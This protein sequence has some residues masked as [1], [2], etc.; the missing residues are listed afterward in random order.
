MNIKNI[1]LLLVI[2]MNVSCGTTYAATT[3]RSPANGSTTYTTTPT[4]AWDTVSGATGYRLVL[5]EN[6]AFSG[7]DDGGLAENTSCTDSSC[8]MVRVSESSYE[9]GTDIQLDL[10]KT[11]YW[12]VRDTVSSDWSSAFHFTLA[13]KLEKPVLSNP[14][15]AAQDI[16][17]S[18]Q[19]FRWSS[20][21]GATVYRIVVLEDGHYDDFVDDGGE[22]YCADS[23]TCFTDTTASTNYSGF[24]LKE[25]TKYFWL[26]RAGSAYGIPDSGF[27]ADYFTT[28]TS[29]PV[30][31]K[32]PVLVSGSATPGS[33]TSGEQV[34]FEST[35]ND[36]ENKSVVDVQVR[37]RRQGTTSWQTKTLG[38][39][40]GY[41]FSG[42][43][44]IS[45]T[46][47]TYEY[48]FRASDAD[49]PSGDRTNTTNWLAGGSFDV[50]EE[51]TGEVDRASLDSE[52]YED[53]TVLTGNKTFT[54][55]WTLKNTGTTTWDS[56]Y[57]LSYISG[58]LSTDKQAVAI[59]GTVA[60][61]E[62]FT[63]SVPMKTPE[64]QETDQTYSDYWKFVNPEGDTV[65]VSGSSKI[66]VRI[67][68]AGTGGSQDGSDL[69]RIASHLFDI[70]LNQIDSASGANYKY[71]LWGS[72][73]AE[74]YTETE[75]NGYKGGHSG[76]DMQTK[77]VA[78]DKTADRKFYA[79]SAGTV[80]AAGSD[81]YN[82]I[83]I[84]DEE[85][86]ITTLYLHAREV[87]IALESTV[88]VGTLLGVQGDTA[89]PAEHVH[90]EV[91]KGY[92]TGPA[93]GAVD[94]PNPVPYLIAYLDNNKQELTFDI[95]DPACSGP[96]QCNGDYLEEKGSDEVFVSSD[97]NKLAQAAVH[98]TGFAADGVTRLLLRVQTDSK[99]KFQLLSADDEL[100]SGDADNCRFGTLLNLAETT[101]SCGS[102]EVE[103]VST[104]AGN[105]AFAILKAPMYYPFDPV[106]GSIANVNSTIKAKVTSD[107]QTEKEVT[108]AVLPAPTVLVHGVW[109][110][111]DSMAALEQYLE[112]RGITI[113]EDCRPTHMG[114]DALEFDPERGVHGTV[115]RVRQSIENAINEFRNQNIACAQ[116]TVV[117]HSLGGLLARA[118]IDWEIRPFQTVGNYNKGDIYKIITIGTPHEGS[119]LAN[120]FIEHQCDK[121]GTL[122]VVFSGK[123][124]RGDR[125]RD[126]LD[127][128]DR[129]IG[130]AIYGLQQN[131][132]ALSHIGN[133]D[134]LS[135]AIVGIAP[136][137]SG[138]E[139]TLNDLPKNSGNKGTTI[140]GLL[141]GNNNH[142]TI[143][144][145]QSQMGGIEQVTEI[146]DIVHAAIEDDTDET[147]SNEV[148]EQVFELLLSRDE[149][150]FG[151]FPAPNVD[152]N[153][154]APNEVIATCDANN[155][156]TALR[157]ETVFADLA[158][159]EPQ[160]TLSPSAGTVVTAGS[161]VTI[162][163][164]IENDTP[165]EG[166]DGVMFIVGQSVKTISGTSPYEFSFQVPSKL[167]RLNIFAMA[168]GDDPGYYAASSYLTVVPGETLEQIIPRPSRA[169]LDMLNV[170]F[171]LRIEGKFAS[172]MVYDIT[173]S[174]TGTSY[175]VQAGS[176]EI[177]SVTQEG[178]VTPLRPGEGFINVSNDG[179]SAVVQITVQ[180][181][182]IYDT[183]QDGIN[184]FDEYAAGLDP[185]NPDSDNDGMP[186]GW[187]VANGLNPLL[188]DSGGDA[189][190]DGFSNLDEYLAG[191]DPQDA[192]STP[193]K[194]AVIVP[195][196]F[197]SIQDAVNYVA[198]YAFGG[199]VCVQPGTYTEAKLK[200][201]DGVYLVALS[202]DPAATVIDGNGKDDVITFQ[203]VRVGG[204]IGFTLR[205]SKKNGNAAAVNIAGDK[206]MPLI[207]RNIITDNRHGIRLQGNVMPLLIN[208]TIADNTGDGIS[209]GG[210]SPATI[211]NNIVA[212]N[213][214]DGI[215]SKG[216]AIDELARNDVYNNKGGDYVGIEAGEGGISL[217]PRF[218]DGYQLASDSPCIGTGL[219]LDGEAVD[220]GAYGNSTASLLNKT[221]AAT[222]AD[223]DHDGIDDSWELLF[224]GNLQTA[225]SSSD[226]DQ[227]GYSDLQEYL[228]NCNRYIDPEGASFDPTAAN[229]P[230][231]EG[232]VDDGEEQQA[233]RSL[234]G[235]LHLLLN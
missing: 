23:T 98:R 147:A 95:V 67:K 215:S 222:F 5:S 3:L 161:T 110:S 44:T 30:D 184:D 60:P 219:T 228:N 41:T 181:S 206:Q 64:A 55:T 37:F 136:E 66:W 172:G 96:T 29:G 142:D 124:N 35:W 197:S 134:V 230:G 127:H 143:V 13:A 192:S 71:N 182:K 51:P 180:L 70:P 62:L 18:S 40:S 73:P 224:F 99:V 231:G 117:G 177:I 21:T 79:V 16:S 76:I 27:V 174:E 176:E 48:Q 2:F 113:C 214:G 10:G 54:K 97:V 81:K 36:P 179:V 26:V 63:F 65:T 170:P 223:S 186:D 190:G 94:T 203:G 138:T 53:D 118:R 56:S 85:Q 42:S 130:P 218:T 187:E 193:I 166:V 221:E 126:V 145:R 191:T 83:A 196:D 101:E 165:V 148:H 49:T 171:S 144:E 20:V 211:L 22:S 132:V 133:S 200:L 1:L 6:S 114:Q 33:I 121:M 17:I 28:G 45:G 102:L 103:P 154:L 155:E 198:A 119:N 216:K 188:D 11:Y 78:G 109:S 111:A 220:M 7:L 59:S 72:K 90:I 140:D 91:R 232:Y 233:G 201:T 112:N 89:A 156:E 153:N 25:G 158:A 157:E 74:Y 87:N 43:Y 24:A 100:L 225:D 123:V 202:N 12:K 137:N 84:Y 107:D 8:Q 178:E 229:A 104:S 207:A 88:V 185:T 75:C 34:T 105:F 46:A 135:H 50:T 122:A 212:D 146:E 234:E 162:N 209:A 93:C 235:V 217:D 86:D 69:Q 159:S 58:I 204:V 32:P 116:A 168:H 128:Q 227:D 199:N 141:G 173:A 195:T 120:W 125:V 189:D 31:N 175:E 163:F 19:N 131:S 15:S 115:G 160:M 47:G 139:N 39:L 167:G 61:N 164:S 108:L 92:H 152:S 169:W 210:N 77:D 129:P 213:K 194:C 151:E 57:K 4:I 14:A 68:V 149:N 38:Y 9:I 183:D 208:N 82:T 106:N 80:I 150:D 205:N 226:Y 52:T